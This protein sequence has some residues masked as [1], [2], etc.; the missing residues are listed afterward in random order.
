M[1]AETI[2]KSTYMDDFMDSVATEEQGIELQRQLSNLLTKAG[3]LARKW[4]S[5]SSRVLGEIQ[6]HD[7]KFEVDLD[8][9][10]LPAAKTLGVWW[11][12]DNDSFTL[13]E[14]QPDETMVYTKRNFL[15][16]IDTLFDPV[17]FLAPYTVRAKLLLQEMW[18]T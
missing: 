16:K 17:G 7:R 4:L 3:M 18:T 6:I 9:E 15:R 2:L 10:G 5:N 11:S 12:A 13:N 14:N 8:R 1:A